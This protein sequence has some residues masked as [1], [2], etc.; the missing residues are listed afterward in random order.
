MIE[1][2]RISVWEQALSDYIDVVRDRPHVYGSH[3]C[4]TLIS[5]AVIVM[6]GVDPMEEFRGQYDSMLTAQKALKS[7]GKGDLAST[8]DDKFPVMPVSRA[9][10]GDIVLTPLAD[11]PAAGIVAGKDAWF[12]GDEG[13]VKIPRPLWTRAWKIG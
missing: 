11:M 13:L 2:E 4:C 6:C 3:D 7:I 1:L 10:E 8:L 9:R 12:I 5:G